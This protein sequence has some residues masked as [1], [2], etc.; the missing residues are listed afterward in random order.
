MDVIRGLK[1]WSSTRSSVISIGNFDGVHR[2]H[3]SIINI[4]RE[5]SF[6]YR[7]LSV[8]VSFNRNPKEYFGSEKKSILSNLREK[9]ALLEKRKLDK[10]LILNFNDALANLSARDFVK[11]ILLEKLKLKCLVVGKDFRFG[12]KREGDINLLHDFAK[13]FLFELIVLNDT[14]LDDERISSTMIREHLSNGDMEKAEVLLGE[15]YSIMGRVVHGRKVARTL[16]FPTANICLARRR[17]PALR[18]VYI[19]RL[20]I[21]QSCYFGV[22]NLGNRP[23]LSGGNLSL[24]VHLFVDNINLY[25]KHVR[26]EFL[27]K[28][29]SEKKFGSF[30][31]LKVAVFEDVET[32]REWLE[33]TSMPAD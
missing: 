10:L 20:C 29:R 5:K 3:R 23:T 28:I 17:N 7:A 33:V 25:S 19:V 4:L 32:A 18:G 30:E 31:E 16:G 27:H 9:T 22:A 1:N 24:E 2:G 8:L 13:E 21:A 26:V 12:K 11:K 14:T 6:E 15:K